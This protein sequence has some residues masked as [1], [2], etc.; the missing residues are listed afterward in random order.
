M[1]KTKLLELDNWQTVI[2]DSATK[3]TAK[4]KDCQTNQEDEM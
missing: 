3:T 4:V 1:Q 2:S